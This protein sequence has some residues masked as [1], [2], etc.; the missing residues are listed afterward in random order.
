MKA[1]IPLTKTPDFPH[2]LPNELSTFSS[3]IDSTSLDTPIQVLIVATE[4]LFI[5][6]LLGFF[7]RTSEFQVRAQC[8]TAPG[9]SKALEDGAVDLI[10]L[11]VSL[12]SNETIFLAALPPLSQPPTIIAMAETEATAYRAFELDAID[13]ILKSCDRIRF[14]KA[15]RRVKRQVQAERKV[16]LNHQILMSV[17]ELKSVI[18]QYLNHFVIKNDQSSFLLKTEKIDWIKAEGNYICLHVGQDT[19]ILREKIGEVEHQLNPRQFIRIHRSTIV[20]LDRVARLFP[21]LHGDFKVILHDT[22][23][24]TL[25]RGYRKN[26]NY[27]GI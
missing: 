7:E 21:I 8:G 15:L 13:F 23:E 26:L 17:K 14:E 9:V 18:P 10:L 25:S 6:K 16:S 1:P 20:N 5:E 2:S 22:T 12:V 24:L 11:D 4:I 27:L 19:H 3:P